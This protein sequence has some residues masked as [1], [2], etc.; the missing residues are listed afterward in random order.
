MLSQENLII[1][2]K[3]FVLSSFQQKLYEY[4]N[5]RNYSPYVVK[6]VISRNCPQGSP[7]VSLT[8]QRL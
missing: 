4:K 2:N 1:K 7:M 8:K 6:K 3:I 5:N